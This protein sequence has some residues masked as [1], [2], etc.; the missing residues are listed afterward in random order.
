MRLSL[1]ILFICFNCFS[2]KQN[3]ELKVVYDLYFDGDIPITYPAVLHI[4]DSTTIY[5]TLVAQRQKWN[6]SDLKPDVQNIP[7]NRNNVIPDGFL[8]INHHSKELLTFELLPTVS[9][10]VNDNYP[11]MNWIISEKRKNIAGYTCI[12]ATTFYR[13]RDWIAWFTPDIA[14]PYGP[15]KFCGLPGLVLEVSSA[16]NNYILKAIKVEQ[17][18]SEIF[19]REFISLRKTYNKKP[20]TYK[21]FLA[22]REEAFENMAEKMRSDGVNFTITTPPRAGYELKYEWEE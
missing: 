2:Q 22:D 4:K 16:D 7:D 15:W 11:V 14:M 13:G 19:D 21:Q 3:G 1:I 18:R 6:T 12:K 8:K 9:M 10:L 5:Q 20:I 17:I